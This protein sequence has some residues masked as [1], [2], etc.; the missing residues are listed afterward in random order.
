MLEITVPAMELWDEVNE[1]FVE[2]DEQI[3][4]LEH[5][6][7]SLY[8]WESKWNKP[9]I[10]NTKKT[11]EETL[12]YIRCMTLNKIKDPQ[13]YNFLSNE[14]V[15]KIEQYISAPM[16]A[17][18]I[19]ANSKSNKKGELITAELIYYWMF[20]LNIPL[21]WENRHLNQ[22]ITLIQVCNVKNQPDKKMG[23]KNVMNQNAALNA[24]RRK[25]LNSKG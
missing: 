1:E 8:K 21:E 12:D 14:N 9:F 20:S 6:L 2:T 11:R 16:T 13:I 19:N 23:K 7:V 22:L 10:N 3:L 18:V 25:R 17:T 24:A 15:Q 5:S 4:I